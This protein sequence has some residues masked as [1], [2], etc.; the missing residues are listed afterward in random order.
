MFHVRSRIINSFFEYFKENPISIPHILIK[1]TEEDGV[2]S[3]F[4][5][6]YSKDGLCTAG[7]VL[8]IKPDHH[9]HLLMGAGVGSNTKVGIISL[10]ALLLVTRKKGI[11]NVKIWRDSRVMIDWVI[12]FSSLHVINLEHWMEK[13]EGL[14]DYFSYISFN[15]IYREHNGQADSLS[16]KSIGV[17]DG[18][19]F[20]E[21]Y[22]D[23]G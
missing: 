17:L 12:G 1:P 22:I 16:K 11:L 8:K 4:F 13:I 15:H 6:K 21:E 3:G 5:H 2:A 18:S 14:K 23:D 7:M 19:L 20:F 9:I 10:W